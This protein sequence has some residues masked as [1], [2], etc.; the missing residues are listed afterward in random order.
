MKKSNILGG[1][2]LIV[3]AVIL[4]GNGMGVLPNIP[5]FGL[6][7]SVLLGAYVI[8]GIW[9][10]EFFGAVMSL[11]F[12]AWIWDE[13]LMIEKITPFPLLLAAALLG[14]G[15]NMIIGKKHKIVTIHREEDGEWKECT[16]DEARTA[17]WQDGRHVTLE[18]NFNSVSKYVNSDAFSSANLE[19]NFGSTNIYFNNAV[20]A[21][22]QATI[23]IENNF[24]EMNIYLPRTWRMRLSQ[25]TAFANVHVYGA[26]NNDMDAPLVIVKAESNFGGVK[27]YF[28]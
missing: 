23:D 5:W 17:N 10:R 25:E 6:I 22:N 19:N 15:L 28:D 18:N 21:G 16:M 14:I 4:L 1:L 24:G 11:G 26:P 9:K 7:G 20:I 2:A 13:Y 3:I 12:I 8:K 27:I